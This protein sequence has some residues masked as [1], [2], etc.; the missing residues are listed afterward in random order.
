MNVFLWVAALVC[1]GIA[2][3][4]TAS[5]AYPDLLQPRRRERSV[6]ANEKAG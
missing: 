2:A 6:E 1:W 5:L 4:L 3:L